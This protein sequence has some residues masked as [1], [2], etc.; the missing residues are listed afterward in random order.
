MK[1]NHSFEDIS[2]NR[3][4]EL[5]YICLQYGENA[6]ELSELTRHI[7]SLGEETEP[8]SYDLR[9][10]A[11]LTDRLD[12]IQASIE[13]VMIHECNLKDS[14]ERIAL[15]KAIEF[16]VCNGKTFNYL[17]S[18]MENFPISEKTFFGLVRFF[19]CFLDLRCGQK[20]TLC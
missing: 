10:F 9:R 2:K 20:V 8:R 5:Q 15:K 13:D 17:F 12:D 11:F 7:N 4:K 6:A 1:T 16:H 19:Y 14:D 18:T 3:K